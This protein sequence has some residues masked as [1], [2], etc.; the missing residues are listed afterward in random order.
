MRGK[1]GV[2]KPRTKRCSGFLLSFGPAS[3]Q[4]A[5]R[6]HNHE[7]LLSGIGFPGQSLKK[8]YGLANP[9]RMLKRIVLNIQPVEILFD[10]QYPPSGSIFIPAGNRL[11]ENWPYAA[12]QANIMRGHA[13]RN[14]LHLAHCISSTI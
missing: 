6:G 14:R 4:H 2:G 12:R 10:G 13:R 8:M 11:N 9:A 5:A 7:V 1:F 3:A